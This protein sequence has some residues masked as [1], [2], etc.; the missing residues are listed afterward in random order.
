MDQKWS[1]FKL[2]DITLKLQKASVFKLSYF[3]ESHEK[4]NKTFVTFEIDACRERRPFLI[5]RDFVFARPSGNK[6]EPF[7]VSHYN[8]HLVYSMD[9]NIYSGHLYASHIS[10]LSTTYNVF[11][12][13]TGCYLSSGG[14]H[15]CAG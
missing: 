11:K 1:K 10:I 9:R 2:V 15:N 3:T 12:C 13:K 5:S 4:E 7:Q 14:E 8:F 6:T